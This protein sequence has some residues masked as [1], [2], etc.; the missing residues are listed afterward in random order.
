MTPENFE[1]LEQQ[2]RQLAPSARSPTL[3]ARIT[4]S[5]SELRTRNSEPETQ[6]Q[7]LRTQ[8]LRN[9]ELRT[10]ELKTRNSE[11][12][13]DR[14]LFATLSTAAAAL[15][16]IIILLGSDCLTARPTS[17]ELPATLAQTRYLFIQ[18]AQDTSGGKFQESS[19]V[20]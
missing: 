7:E 14:L 15:I 13:G 8:E 18:L 16:V 17:P 2:L 5:L 20:P 11:L 6:N 12:R 10:Q 1:H 3:N 19:L 4:H 9:S